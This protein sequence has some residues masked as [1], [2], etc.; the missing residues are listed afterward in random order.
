MF[1]RHGSVI[2]IAIVY[3]YCFSDSLH[4]LW[5]L[6]QIAISPVQTKNKGKLIYHPAKLDFLKIATQL[7]CT[8]GP[9]NIPLILPSN[10]EVFRARGDCYTNA[11][12]DETMLLCQ[13]LPPGSSTLPL[14]KL[15]PSSSL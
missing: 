13:G 5:A 1:G 11:S 7:C 14:L 6:W 8:Q 4:T 2:I 10:G 3:K 9:A 15:E 12:V